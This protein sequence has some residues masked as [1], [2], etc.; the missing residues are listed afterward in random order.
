MENDKNNLTYSINF[1]QNYEESFFCMKSKKAPDE[2]LINSHE[3]R[4]YLSTPSEE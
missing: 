1:A 2:D 3:S 4:C